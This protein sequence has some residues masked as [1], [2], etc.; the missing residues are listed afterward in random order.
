MSV[1]LSRALS[2]LPANIF[3]LTAWRAEVSRAPGGEPSPYRPR[4][5]PASAA[6]RASDTMA[7][8]VLPASVTSAPGRAIASR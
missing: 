2:R 7:C 6:A 8:L 5:R 3:V 1:G 4:S